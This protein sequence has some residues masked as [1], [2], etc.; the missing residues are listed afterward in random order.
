MQRTSLSPLG[1]ASASDLA[2]PQVVVGRSQS[3][4]YTRGKSLTIGAMARDR[5]GP[6]WRYKIYPLLHWVTT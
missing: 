6:S 2:K 1:V 3:P 5:A 4:N